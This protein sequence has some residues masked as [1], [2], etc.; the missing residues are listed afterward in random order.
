MYNK[1]NRLKE[2]KRM[3]KDVLLSVRGLQMEERDRQDVVETISPGQYYFRNGKHFFL[4]EEVTEGSKKTTK[5]MLKVTDDYMEL[6]KKGEVNVHM[7]FEKNKKN[8]TYYYTPFG[9]LLMG[10]DAYRVD[11]TERENEIEVEVEYSLE[12][13]NEFLA[14]CHILIRAVPRKGS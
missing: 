6:T 3:T 4:Y 13:N 1:G 2:G 7:I 12:I 11:I 8:V 10:I 9:S 5:N 14:N